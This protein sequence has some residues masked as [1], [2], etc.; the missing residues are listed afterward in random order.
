[1]TRTLSRP[2]RIAW[3]RLARTSRVGPLSFH[4]LIGRFRTAAAA[5]EALPRI[6]NLAAAP[7]ERAEREI[8]GVEAL[9][10]RLI[11]SCEPDYP[12]LLAQLDAPPP[13]LAIRGNAALLKRPT[14]AVIG[15]REG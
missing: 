4:R 8:E 3:T 7:E 5:L 9:G 1:M 10:A 13:L 11:A 14:V 12:P 2:E 6:S 15:S